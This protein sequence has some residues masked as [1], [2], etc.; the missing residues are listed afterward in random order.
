[1]KSL[2]CAG[3]LVVCVLAG[4]CAV[5]VPLLPLMMFAEQPA[6]VVGGTTQSAAITHAVPV[7]NMACAE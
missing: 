7:G 2:C 5:G 1:M 6:P 4:G 3:L